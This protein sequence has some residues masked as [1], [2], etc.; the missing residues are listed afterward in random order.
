MSF[1]YTLF[2]AIHLKYEVIFSI[3]SI[4]FADHRGDVF[5]WEIVLRQ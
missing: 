4:N 3:N 2:G 5:K 1:V